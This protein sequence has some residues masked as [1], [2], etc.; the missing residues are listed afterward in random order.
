[1]AILEAKPGPLAVVIEEECGYGEAVS[2]RAAFLVTSGGRKLFGT[3]QY[4]LPASKSPRERAAETNALIY[5]DLASLL[6]LPVAVSSPSPETK[7]VSL[8]AQT[9]PAEAKTRKGGK[10]SP[11]P[12]AVEPK[13]AAK[14]PAPPPP[15]APEPEPEPALEPEPAPE[16]EPEPEPE[17]E[18]ESGRKWPHATPPEDVL[19]VYGAATGQ[20][21]GAQSLQKL[22]WLSGTAV[23][24]MRE[25]G[26]TMTPEEVLMV[27]AASFLVDEAEAAGK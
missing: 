25:G 4:M 26:R 9:P 12:S 24:R 6:T 19:I 21:V 15:P 27:Q 23:G 10:A 17:S 20:K 14:A 18:P 11:A 2:V 5:E 3:R 16:P 7:V 13:A 8:P 22:R 1:M